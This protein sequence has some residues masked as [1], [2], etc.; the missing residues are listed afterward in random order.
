MLP[1]RRAGPADAVQQRRRW[2]LVVLERGLVLAVWWWPELAELPRSAAWAAAA[3]WQTKVLE[4]SP[5][6]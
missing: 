2:V 6:G 1:E 5:R 4:L 3:G